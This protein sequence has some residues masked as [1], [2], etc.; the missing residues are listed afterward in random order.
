MEVQVVPVMGPADSADALDVRGP[1]TVSMVLDTGKETVQL[2]SNAASAP[3]PI[4]LASAVSLLKSST[5]TY[6]IKVPALLRCLLII[7]IPGF[8]TRQ[9]V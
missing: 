7:P 8:H 1:W 3:A 4:T 5:S 2:P 6:C 9:G